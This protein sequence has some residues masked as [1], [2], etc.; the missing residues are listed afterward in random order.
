MRHLQALQVEQARIQLVDL[1]K[2]TG[3]RGIVYS[4]IRKILFIFNGWV[5]ISQMTGLL[6]QIR[7]IS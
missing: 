7:C 5:N 2:C 1:Q 3:K 6:D 4:D